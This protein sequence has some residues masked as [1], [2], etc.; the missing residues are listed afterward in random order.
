MLT[1]AAHHRELEYLHS[2]IF[3]KN[4]AMITFHILNLV[5]YFLP[6][7]TLVSY[8][9]FVCLSTMLGGA[10][11]VGWSKKSPYVNLWLMIYGLA[12]I[13]NVFFWSYGCGN[14]TTVYP[15]IIQYIGEPVNLIVCIILALGIW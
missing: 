9:L 4:P 5:T 15:Y 14:L 13:L 10:T 6:G 11:Y 8:S 1:V 12:Y 3:F 7:S 2:H